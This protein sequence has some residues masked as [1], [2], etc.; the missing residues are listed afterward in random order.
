LNDAVLRDETLNAILLFEDSDINRRKFATVVPERVTT[1]STGAFL[2]ELEKAGKIQS[3]DRIL[4]QA[5][6]KGRNV[7]GQRQ[8]GAGVASPGLRGSLFSP[9]KP[10][11]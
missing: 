9:K 6:A 11:P 4:D 2:Q 10:G 8:F 7:D 1:I 5:M 3:A